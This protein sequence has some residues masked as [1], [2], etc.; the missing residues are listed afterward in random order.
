MLRSAICAFTRIF[1]ALWQCAAD[2]VS[3]SSV[4]IGPG[5]AEERE[6]HYTAF[7]TRQEYA[8]AAVH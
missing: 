7:G 5:S 6:E 4:D 3:T 1:D 8:L 2:R